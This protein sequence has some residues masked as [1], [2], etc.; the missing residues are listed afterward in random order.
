MNTMWKKIVWSVIAPFLP[1]IIAAIFKLVKGGVVN[2]IAWLE[3]KASE[4]DNQID[5]ALVDGIKQI[6]YA[7]G[8]DNM[9]MRGLEAVV[10]WAHAYAKRTDND[11]D[12]G[13]VEAVA[14]VLGIDLED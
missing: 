4:T 9:A 11:W 13:V 3:T 7:S 8:D 1:K 2:G 6:V 5:D 14:A 12:D 10:Q